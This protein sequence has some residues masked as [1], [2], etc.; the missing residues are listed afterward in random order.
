MIFGYFCTVST[1]QPRLVPCVIECN[2]I[3]FRYGHSCDVWCFAL[4][5]IYIW[6]GLSPG[7]D[8]LRTRKE[9][10]DFTDR[11]LQ[12]PT[13]QHFTRFKSH[14]AT[15]QNPPPVWYIIHRCLSLDPS[16]RPKKAELPKLLEAAF[17]KGKMT[18]DHTIKVFN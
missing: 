4:V 16:G 17:A 6:T 18:N 8:G 5:V 14:I 13:F 2:R 9:V 7:Y 11:V 12:T 3:E 1:I 10:D 15:T